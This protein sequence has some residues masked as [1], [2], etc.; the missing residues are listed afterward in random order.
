MVRVWVGIWVVCAAWSA[1][2]ANAATIIDS[3]LYPATITLNLTSDVDISNGVS[4]FTQTGTPGYGLNSFG[5][6]VFAVDHGIETDVGFSLSG[7]PPFGAYKSFS[8]QYEFF[9]GTYNEPPELGGTGVVALLKDGIGVGQPFESLFGVAEAEVVTA[10][11]NLSNTDESV[12]TDA[13]VM[14]LSLAAKTLDLQPE[15]QPLGG[16][17]YELAASQLIAFSDGVAVGTAA[18]GLE[19][20]RQAPPPAVP[21]PA[22]LALMGS[23]AVGLFVGRALRRSR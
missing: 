12:R 7:T 21:E 17:V 20:G 5:T 8:N 2:V 19:F 3:N 10:L 4:F 18:G 6:Y 16:D 22:S 23:A 1:N 15:L 14:L 11:Q 9:L 13:I